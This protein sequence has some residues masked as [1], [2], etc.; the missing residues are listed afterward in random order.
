VIHMYMCAE[1]VLSATIKKLKAEG[2]ESK[3]ADQES[4]VSENL[5]HV[6]IYMC[7]THVHV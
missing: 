4:G 5:N 6:A 1:I 2:D 7:D 3:V